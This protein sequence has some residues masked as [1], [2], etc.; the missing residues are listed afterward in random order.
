[1]V[2]FP[3]NSNEVSFE[4]RMGDRSPAIRAPLEG[5]RS[6]RS[7]S[8]GVKSKAA[9]VGVKMIGG[10]YVVVVVV[11]LFRPKADSDVSFRS[12]KNENLIILPITNQIL[13]KF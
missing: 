6:L 3:S 9:V 5:P 2:D 11:V 10:L 13:S 12:L 8:S 1:M 7:S 4:S